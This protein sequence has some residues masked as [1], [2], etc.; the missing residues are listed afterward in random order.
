MV[1]DND[2]RLASGA[3]ND[4]QEVQEDVDD[5][6]IEI[7]RREDV[8]LRRDGVLM[9]A[10]HHELDIED[11]VAAEDEGADRC[12]HHA[13]HLVR[14]DD[15]DDS[16]YEQD[17][18]GNEENA[19]AGGE[20]PFSLHGEDGESEANDGADAGRDENVIRPV[21]GCDTSKHDTFAE[22]EETK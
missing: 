1:S 13:E 19:A 12:V 8:L 17:N 7:E 14:E 6:E 3:A 2:W 4:L 11:Q 9:F 5:V 22:S 10:A 21:E 18:D 20:V 16:E 15:W